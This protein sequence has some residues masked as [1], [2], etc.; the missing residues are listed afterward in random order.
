MAQRRTA[1]GAPMSQDKRSARAAQSPRYR[2][3]AKPA[4]IF[5]ATKSLHW[6]HFKVLSALANL[7]RA[8]DTARA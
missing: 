4:G 8:R 3:G 2:R 7:S 1:G 5:P 6:P